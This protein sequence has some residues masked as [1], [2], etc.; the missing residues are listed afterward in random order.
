MDFDPEQ[1]RAALK[2]FMS[3]ATLKA[4]PWEA[5]SGLGEGTLRK[6][7][8]GKT[9][10]LTDRTYAKLA[11]GASR[12]TGKIVS[13]L[14]L[15]E[16]LTVHDSVNTEISPAPHVMSEERQKIVTAPPLPER[17][18]MNRDIPVMGTSL[19]GRE[20]DFQ[21]NNGDPIDFV[22]RP[23][24][25]AGRKGL[26]ALYVQ[27]DSMRPWKKPGQLVFIDAK[28]PQIGDHVVIELR[29]TGP[30]D[31]RPAFLKLLLAITPTKVKVAQYK[32]AREFEILR[33][34]VHKIYRVL[35]VEEVLGF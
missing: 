1:R 28:T 7:L 17:A 18:S 13:I 4:S 5:E 31:D 21:M 34:K 3:R 19:A 23:S 6:F 24:H 29:P 9:D 11:A 30:D 10:T 32:P 33:A 14:D 2:G 26:M 27:G 22:R 15:Q 12:L 8:D 20:G 16:T 25:L 35:E